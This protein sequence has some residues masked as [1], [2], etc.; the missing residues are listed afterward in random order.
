MPA[1]SQA[2]IKQRSRYLRQ[3]P[4][5]VALGPHWNTR[6]LIG[7]RFGYL[8]VVADSG[9][10]D[11]SR[12][13]LWRCQCDCGTES[14]RTGATLKEGKSISCGHTRVT[15][16]AIA[17]RVAA[18]R[19]TGSPVR[20]SYSAYLYA[21]KHR[22]H[23]FTLSFEEYVALVH[24]SCHYCGAVPSMLKLTKYETALVNGI[25]RFSNNLGY[26]RDNAVPCCSMCNRMKHAYSAM[27]FLA[28]VRQIAE[29]HPE[30]KAIRLA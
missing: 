5:S 22:G 1:R 3:A 21:A 26:T 6:S 19:R 13:I 14:L 7:R 17:R 20:R 16:I 29:R 27:E 23:E 12:G 10:R 24:S 8:V 9:K 25:D 15:P 30:G 11:K 4:A 2:Q 18:Q 28:K